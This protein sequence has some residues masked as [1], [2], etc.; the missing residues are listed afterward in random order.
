MISVILCL[1]LSQQRKDIAFLMILAACLMLGA[2]VVSYLNPVFSF[3]KT[4]SSVGELDNVLLSTMLKCVGIGLI[5]D[6]T[7]SICNDT[8]NGAMGKLLQ[9]LASVVILGL[10]IPL[11]QRLLSL[12]EE[13]LNTI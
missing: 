6:I 9:T 8:G 2:V 12:V 7:A 10:S 5:G 13:I 3:F 4:L 11:F 1:V